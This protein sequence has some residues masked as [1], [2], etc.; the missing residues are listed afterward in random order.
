MSADSSTGEISHQVHVWAISLA[1]LVE[2]ELN[3]LNSIC[4]ATEHQKA[5]RFIFDRDRYAYLAAHGLVRFALSEYDST[6]SPC[7]WSFHTGPHG[8][9]EIDTHLGSYLRFNLSHCATRVVC[10]VS[11]IIDCGIDVEPIKRANDCNT[12]IEHCL[13]AKEKEWVTSIKTELQGGRFIQ[14]W[15]LKEAVTKAVGLG[16]NIP[17]DELDI[18]ITDMPR[19]R[20]APISIAQPWWLKQQLTADDHIEALALRVDPHDN[21]E[22][23]WNEWKG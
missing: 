8:R 23:S 5:D 10:V 3:Y 16:L 19:I 18:E 13:T 1:N 4:D 6:Y 2:T 11:K 17:F 20:Q 12:L 21:V 14:I 15:T 7:E 9:P 22:L